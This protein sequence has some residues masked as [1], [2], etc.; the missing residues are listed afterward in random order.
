MDARFV[1]EH[2]NVNTVVNFV[3]YYVYIY[4]R[5]FYFLP[6][7]VYCPF[8]L[9]VLSFVIF[10]RLASGRNTFPHLWDIKG[11]LIQILIQFNKCRTNLSQCWVITLHYQCWVMLL[12]KV[13]HD[14]KRL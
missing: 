1:I 10:C 11:F 8:L 14:V 9:L 12:L 6:F 3:L 13:T 5:L 2:M 7:K 4:V